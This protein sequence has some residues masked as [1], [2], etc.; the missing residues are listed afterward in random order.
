MAMDGQIWIVDF[1][2]QYTQLITRRVREVGHSGELITLAQLKKSFKKKVFPKALILSGGPLSIFEDKEDYS[3]I[4]ENVDLP[5]LGICYGMQIMGKLFNGE[6][7]KGTI[8]EYGHA[9][10]VQSEEHFIKDCPDSLNV[11]MSHSDHITKIPDGFK[12][13]FVS[14]NNHS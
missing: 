1:G 9:Q 3:F 6:V 4:F 5:I 13:C 12:P 11:W 7:E 14:G 2:S 8:G 10:V